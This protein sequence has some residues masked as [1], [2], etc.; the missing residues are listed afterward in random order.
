M[1]NRKERRAARKSHNPATSPSPRGRG[2]EPS[3]VETLLVHGKQLLATGNDEAA[4]AIACQT[5]LI[6]QT[7]DAKAFFVACVKRWSY[8]PGAEEMQAILAR[9]LREAWTWPNQLLSPVLGVLR[10]DRLIAAALDR[11]EA[12]WPRR[13]AAHELLG[14]TGLAAIADHQ[15][16]GALLDSVNIPDLAFERF[17]TTLRC[18]VLQAATEGGIADDG[19]VR[20][21]AALAQ[22]C[23]INE[24][25][26]DLTPDERARIDRLH[27]AIR[28]AFERDAPVQP[29]A[30]AAIAAYAGLDSL[31]A[32]QLRERSWPDSLSE[33][34]DQQVRLPDMLRRQRAT[35]PRLTPIADEVSL[36]VRD[37]YEENPYPRWV[38]SPSDITPLTVDAYLRRE[39][40]LQIFEA[41]PPPSRP[42]ILIAGCGTGQQSIYFAQC[43]AGVRGLAVDLSLSSLS[44]AKAKTAAAGLNNITY[45]QA[46]ILELGRLG[47]HFDVIVSSGVLHHLAEPMA[48]L[49]V[50]SSLLRPGGFMYLGLYSELARRGIV[51]ARRWISERGYKATPSDIR[52]CRQELMRVD[53]AA[54]KGIFNMVDFFSTSEC[55]DLLFHVQE[56]RLTLPQIATFAER[57]G[58]KFLGFNVSAQIRR[59]FRARF[60]ADTDLSSLAAWHAFET[61]NPDTFIHMYQF[62]VQKSGRK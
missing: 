33:L 62:W 9:A 31:P 59:Q 23:F 3:V 53:N 5:I 7:R 30:L 54:W 21:A 18:A 22:Q 58:L 47:R 11:V 43:I 19:I 41:P 2:S 49:Q 39:F 38:R 16:L 4:L 26:Y 28:E 35:I 1:I 34:L 57:A 42:D 55:R 51:A 10:K 14:P 15:L 27:A 12:A 48:G 40:P 37:Q 32:R 46:D 60:P 56:H 52:A 6:E 29:L 36:V 25:V 61:E 24:Y 50:L 17:F 45:A 8:F 44:Y 20:V 13:L